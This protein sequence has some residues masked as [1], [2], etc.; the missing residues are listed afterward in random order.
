MIDAEQAIY[1]LQHRQTRA[2][3]L[4]SPTK[5]TPIIAKT[6]TILRLFWGS[7]QNLTHSLSLSL[8]V[9]YFLGDNLTRKIEL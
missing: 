4:Q 3:F 8:S 5:P 7:C 1:A 6:K 2:R 9:F